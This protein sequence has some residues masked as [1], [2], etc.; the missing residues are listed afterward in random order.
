MTRKYPYFVLIISMTAL[1]FLLIHR[2]G[3][4]V[5]VAVAQNGKATDSPIADYDAETLKEKS[6]ARKEKD[7]HFKGFGNPDPR[8]PIIELPEAV[9]PLPSNSHWWIGLSALPVEQ[10]DLV[11]LGDIV[12]RQAHLTGDRSGIYSE[13]T[14]QIDRIFKD[15]TGSLLVASLLQ[16]N[17][18]GG[19]V[20]F[21]SG[22]IQKYEIARQGMPG[23]GSRYVLFL[24]K[25]AE[26]DLLILT[27]YELSI[28]KVTPLDGE[29]R[30]DPRSSLPFAKY[31]GAVQT[32]LLKDLD[33]AS[34]RSTGEGTK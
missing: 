13:F 32:S 29:D 1:M 20:R 7:S 25:T 2:Q 26:G 5:P 33:E 23:T 30:S 19:T 27:G 10:S 3:D 24:R 16:V 17:R 22:K 4:A 15:P 34:A 11:V 8:K 28:G 6:K 31:R 18:E 21:A 12:D 9:E 14:V